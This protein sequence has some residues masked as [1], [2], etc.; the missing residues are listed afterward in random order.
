MTKQ[1]VKDWVYFSSQLH[2]HHPGGEELKAGAWDRNWHRRHRGTP[3]M[4]Y[5]LWLV[6]LAFL[7]YPG[8]PAKGWHCPLHKSRIKTIPYS[9]SYRP[10]LWGALCHVNLPVDLCQINKILSGT[11]TLPFHQSTHRNISMLDS[12]AQMS[13]GRS[14]HTRLH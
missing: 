1:L 4:A 3:L 8:P 11:G 9:L 10:I 7:Y 5:S 14:W 2:T 6:Q 12:H 13:N